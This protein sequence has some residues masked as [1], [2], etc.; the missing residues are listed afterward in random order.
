MK[1]LTSDDLTLRVKFQRHDSPFFRLR[2][3]ASLQVTSSASDVYNKSNRQALS[4]Y[5]TAYT[6]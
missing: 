1:T 6:T 3:K 2:N 5:M 4:V